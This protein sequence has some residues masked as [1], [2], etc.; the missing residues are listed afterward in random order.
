[1]AECHPNEE[2]G[3]KNRN[4]LP[5]PYKHTD[6]QQRARSGSML[7]GTIANALERMILRGERMDRTFKAI[8][9]MDLAGHSNVTD[10]GF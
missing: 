1:M 5:G 2:G 6:L 9:G 4:E 7:G 3:E 8:K 10:P